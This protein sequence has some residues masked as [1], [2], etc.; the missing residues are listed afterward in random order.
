MIDLTTL[1]VAPSPVE[2]LFHLD[3]DLHLGTA[4]LAGNVSVQFAQALSTEQPPKLEVQRLGLTV[5]GIEQQHVPALSLGRLEVPSL[6][7]LLCSS[8]GL[9]RLPLSVATASCSNCGRNGASR[10]VRIRG[11]F[12]LGPRA[13]VRP[14]CVPARHG[15]KHRRQYDQGEQQNRPML[16]HL[17]R[18]RSGAPPHA[19]R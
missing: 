16:A 12:G 3:E 10:R 8:I 14:A 1:E 19:I 11:S 4:M 15:S 7:L 6:I 18:T 17:I 13:L 9:R 5:C 2:R